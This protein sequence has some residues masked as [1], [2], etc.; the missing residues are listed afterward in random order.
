VHGP[1]LVAGI[2]FVL[3][4]FLTVLGN[5]TAEILTSELHAELSN[6]VLPRNTAGED[7]GQ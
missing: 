3:V 6:I 1:E 5:L 4:E 7:K 2:R